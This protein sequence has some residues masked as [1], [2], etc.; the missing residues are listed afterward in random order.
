VNNLFWAY[1]VV[2]VLHVGYLFSIAVRQNGL[3]REIAS[4]KALLEQR[5]PK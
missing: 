2:W 1:A 3:Q 4:L 5:S